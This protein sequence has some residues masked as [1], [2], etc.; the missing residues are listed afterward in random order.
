MYYG[1]QKA[2]GLGVPITVHAGEWPEKF[3]TLDNIRFAVDVLKV[4][5]IGHGIAL[6]SDK[7]LLNQIKEDGIVA[8]EVKDLFSNVI[9][10]I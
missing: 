4:R 9:K 10:I 2:K 5:R 7:N 3:N 6:R 8:I 1:V